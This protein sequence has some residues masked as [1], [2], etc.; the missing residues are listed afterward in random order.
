V[1]HAREAASAPGPL[2]EV[3]EWA[4][5]QLDLHGDISE[6]LRLTVERIAQNIQ[7]YLGLSP[8]AGLDRLKQAMRPGDSQVVDIAE[9]D[10]RKLRITVK[11]PDEFA[12][13][14]LEFSRDTAPNQMDL[15]PT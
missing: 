1:P 13:Y 11:Q 7:S 15:N 14:W 12:G 3:A 6:F 10:G 9:L 2:D 5:F 4:A 8:D